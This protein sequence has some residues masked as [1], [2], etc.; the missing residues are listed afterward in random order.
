[1]IKHITV[2]LHNGQGHLLVGSIGH[3]R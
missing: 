3:I 2:N 1:M